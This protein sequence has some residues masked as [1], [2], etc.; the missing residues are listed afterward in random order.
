MSISRAVWFRIAL[1]GS[2]IALSVAC[3]TV[4]PTE[5]TTTSPSSTTSTSPT[6]S[7]TTTSPT[8][9]TS[10]TSPTSSTTT[11]GTT[12]STSTTTS[13]TTT[14]GG[15]SF[16]STVYN[17]HMVVPPLQT[18]CV[19]C[20]QNA[21]FPPC[22][23]FTAGTAYQFA[24]NT[25]VAGNPGASLFLLKNNGGCAGVGCVSCAG[26]VV[27]G[28]SGGTP[29]TAGGVD[30]SGE[31]AVV[32]WINNG[33]PPEPAPAQVSLLSGAALELLRRPSREF[34]SLRLPDTKR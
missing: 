28:H 5:I 7:T 3:E 24:L 33:R 22:R 6:T 17:A 31:A 13:T 9:S 20:H 32:N 16:Q 11:T 29:W 4:K 23:Q 12:T 30:P 34:R 10:T 21:A 15:A 18:A 25:S 8:T 26:G 1:C 19:T 14:T 2:A 27:L